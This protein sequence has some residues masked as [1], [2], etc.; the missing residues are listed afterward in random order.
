MKIIDVA[1]V[2]RSG[3]TREQ[4]RKLPKRTMPGWL[5]RLFTL[6]NPA[7]RSVKNELGRVRHSDAS[8]AEQVLGWKTRAE[9]ESI[10][11]CGRSLFEHGVIKL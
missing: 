5:A 8:H 1:N 2:L 10:L 6:I 11:D 9:E 7:F 4:T 3:L